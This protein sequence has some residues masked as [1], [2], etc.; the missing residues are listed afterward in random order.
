VPVIIDK[1]EVFIDFHIYAILEFNILIGYPLENLFQEKYALGSLS[2]EFGKI[3]STTHL[4]IPM[5]EHL[6]NHDPFKEVKFI[7]PFVSHRFPCETGCPLSPLLRPKPCP[8]GHQNV[9][10]DNGRE[11]TMILHNENSYAMD[12]LET[13]TLESKRRDSINEHESFT[14]ETPRISCSPSEST[15]FIVLNV[16]CCYEEDNHPSLLVS[17][18][19]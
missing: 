1:I 7:S 3:V 17:K 4:E 19:F 6:P 2:E 8:S 5:A 13:P 11:S 9:I 10:L 18:L 12:I 15:E 16:A 14:F